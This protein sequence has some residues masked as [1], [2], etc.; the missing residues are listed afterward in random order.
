VEILAFTRLSELSTLED[1][2]ERLRLEVLLVEM[3]ALT[4][5]RELST[6]EDELER[7]RLEV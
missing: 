4:E 1:E 5:F 6:L 2:L 3:L 7:L